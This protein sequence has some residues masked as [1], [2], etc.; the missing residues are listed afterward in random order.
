MLFEMLNHEALGVKP[1]SSASFARFTLEH[2]VFADPTF[3]AGLGACENPCC[4]CEAVAF[5]CRPA[6][7][8]DA[9][10]AAP[11]SAGLIFDLDVFSRQVNTSVQRSPDSDALARAVAAEMQEQ[12]WQRLVDVF[13]TIKRR[14]M[15][16]M[17]INAVRAQFPPGTQGSKGAMVGY[18]EI[19]PWADPFAFHLGNTRWVADDMYCVRPGCGCSSSALTFFQMSEKDSHRTVRGVPPRLALYYYYDSGRIELMDQEAGNPAP[20]KFVRALRAANSDLDLTLRDRHQQL[21]LLAERTP[22]SRRRAKRPFAFLR[23]DDAAEPAS[24][25]PP[26]PAVARAAKVGRNDPCPCGS[27]RKYKK[28][29]GGPHAASNLG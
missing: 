9:V 13:L 2:G 6:A 5:M 25:P 29:C 15:K 27:G 26:A 24:A 17:D 14:V 12:D 23:G 4:P 10:G 8:H 18:A 28:C 19:F 16:T 20:D 21:K 1:V 22:K 3:V 7:Q 11:G